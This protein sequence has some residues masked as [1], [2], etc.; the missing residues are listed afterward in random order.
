[1]TS[2]NRPTRLFIVR[3]GESNAQAEGFFSGHATCTGLSSLGRKQAA[4]LYERL[5][6]TREF[7]EVAVLYTSILPRAKETAAIIAPAFGDV[8]IRHDCDWCE[9]HIGEAEGLSYSE[10]QER[11]PARGDPALP[12]GRQIPGC[13]TWAEFYARVGGRLQRVAQDHRGETVVVVGHGGTIAAS[14][15]EL[16]GL[17]LAHSRE[18]NHETRNTA[19]TEWRTDESGWRLARFNDAA[20]LA[21]LVAGSG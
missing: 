21:P 12:F 7:G 17:T 6:A 16:G 3:H 20:H 13:E 1:V 8:P 11:F 18:F 4:A 2:P 15:V 14:V 9:V 19:I 10:L 5:A